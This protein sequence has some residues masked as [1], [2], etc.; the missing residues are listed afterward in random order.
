MGHKV[1]LADDSITVQKIVKLSLTEEGIEVIA[2]GNGEQ[3]V[4]QIEN[5]QPDLVMADVFMP[6]KDGYEVC[7]YVKAH[8]QLSHVPVILLVHA[9]EPF[10]PE[11]AKEA[12]ADHQ[13][14]KPFQSIRTLVS[15]VQELLA[16]PQTGNSVS[17]TVT[18]PTPA[19][20][21]VVQMPFVS[22]QP[23]PSSPQDEYSNLLSLRAHT[24]TSVTAFDEHPG[25]PL[26]EI[27]VA[28]NNF[29]ISPSITTPAMS[30]NMAESELPSPPPITGGLISGDL[31]PPLD[32]L[33]VSPNFSEPSG[34]H[35]SSGPTD[36]FS[37]SLSQPPVEMMAD[38][39]EDVLDIL[40]IMPPPAP[41][42][43][44]PA[45]SVPSHPDPVASFGSAPIEFSSLVQNASP[46]EVEE[47]QPH[48]VAPKI[49]LGAGKFEAPVASYTETAT[50]VT[51]DVQMGTL[52]PSAH[53]NEMNIPESVIEEIVN[54]VVQRLSSKAIQEIAWE[55][56]PEMAE[57]MI[58]KQISQQKHIS[59]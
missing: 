31:M 9:F 8:P 25:L 28:A 38:S 45:F 43:I 12:G 10:D 32:L 6:G 29:T 17:A 13:L 48:S 30:L 24:E 4:S 56:V 11:R 50:P 53:S 39:S 19:P 51:S 54:R 49:D 18:A 40:D 35:F 37:S 26:D 2:F 1:L 3:A 16:K 41:Q 5:I 27:P 42:A 20:A 46:I 14:T 15:T 59:H 44:T 33:A 52:L 47:P 7:E 34:Q 21:T 23:T 36:V 55:I 57:L 22:P 58:R